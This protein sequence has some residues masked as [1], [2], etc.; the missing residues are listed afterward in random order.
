MRRQDVLAGL[1]L[2][3]AFLLFSLDFKLIAYV[4][5]AFGLAGFVYAV[6]KES[7]NGIY[8]T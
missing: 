1:F 5:F 6:I 4:S 2:L 3:L 7:V 8:F